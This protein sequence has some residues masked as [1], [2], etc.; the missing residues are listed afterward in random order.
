MFCFFVTNTTRTFGHLITYAVPILTASKIKDANRCAHAYIGKKFPN[1][2]AGNFTGPLEGHE[3]HKFRRSAQDLT[4]RFNVTHQGPILSL[5]AYIAL[6][7]QNTLQPYNVFVTIQR[8]LSATYPA[9]IL[10]SVKTNKKLCWY[11]GNVRAHR[12]LKSCKILHKSS[13]DCISKKPATGE[14]PS[15]SS[16]VTAVAV[17]W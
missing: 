16:K 9:Q 5:R 15:R 11:R 8:G 6:C 7:P 12:Q 1:F 13:T 17:I 14:W 3:K 10:T 2:C 4:S